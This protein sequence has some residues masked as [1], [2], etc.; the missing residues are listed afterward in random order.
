MNSDSIPQKHCSRCNNS[1]PLE[2]FANSSSSK[3][4]KF[5]YCRKCAAERKGRTW[6]PKCIMLDGYLQC[7]RCG[8]VLPATI[9]FFHRNHKQRLGLQTICISCKKIDD[10]AYLDAHREENRITS[11]NRYYTKVDERLKYREENKER[12]AKTKREWRKNNPD[13]VKAH[14]SESQKRNPEGKKRRMNRYN[15]KHPL[16]QKLRGRI[17]MMRRRVSDPI[18]WDKAELTKMYEAQDGMCAYCGISI[19]WEV[20]YDIHV[21]HIN[22]VVKGGTN[23]LD[24]LCL[25]CADCNLSKN[26]STLAD[27]QARRGW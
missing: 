22:P 20:P 21:D 13:K 4:G 25:A 19:F 27:W 17:S 15:E 3:D 10:A 7:G 24:N 14:K 8:D 23:D 5:H 6:H 18:N 26:D 11:R 16:A 2:S 12:T 1:Y 9:E